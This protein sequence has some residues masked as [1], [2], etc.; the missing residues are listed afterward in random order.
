MWGDKMKYTKI[1][2]H[3]SHRSE[4]ETKA[5]ERVRGQAAI[6]FF[7]IYLS[8]AD[9]SPDL[10]YRNIKMWFD[11]G[12]LT[13][14]QVKALW[15][16]AGV[17]SEDEYREIARVESY[18]LPEDDFAAISSDGALSPMTAEVNMPVWG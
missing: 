5:R 17:L 9:L 18:V 6:A 8:A 13:R 10:K 1:S 15:E 16:S 14:S 12:H 4:Q 11:C 3:I 7:S 2:D